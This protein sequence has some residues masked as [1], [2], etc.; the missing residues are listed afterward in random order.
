MATVLFENL[1]DAQRQAV[2]DTLEVLKEKNTPTWSAI[3]TSAKT[4]KITE[5][6][7]RIPKIS[8]MPGGHTAFTASSTSFNSAV[9]PQSTSMWVYPVRYALPMQFDGGFLRA[10]KGNNPDAIVSY[11]DTLENYAIAASKRMNQMTY[12][13]GT[14]VLAF[15]TNDEAAGAGVTVECD[16]T[17]TAAYGH[18]KGAAWLE[19]GHTYSFY[20]DATGNG[21]A[22]LL[23]TTEGKSSC[24]GTIT[25]EPTTGDGIYDVSAYNKYFRGFA[26]L[27]SNTS[28]VFQ[29]LDT[30][31]YTDLNAYEVDLAGAVATVASIEK[32]KAGLH[33]RNN[34]PK[35]RAGLVCFTTPGQIS[36]LRVQGYNLSQY[37]RNDDNGDVVKGVAEKFVA[38]DT[39][40]VQDADCDED[41][42]YF[43][44]ISQIERFEEMP[45]GE[46]NLD[47]QELRMY[48]GSNN[49]GSDTY[50]RAIGWVGNLGVTGLPRMSAYIKR[51]SITDIATQVNS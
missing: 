28:R 8:R 45:F 15:A 1:G 50:Q 5:K 27:I 48:L 2:A 51:A 16:T 4:R 13:D 24:V 22:T 33:V 29:G 10:F 46:Y 18:T 21:D 39:V 11:Q 49:T 32:A 34:D 25:N 14:G 6:G 17:A 19:A 30:S 43:V 36:N 47:G 37:I 23:V 7:F 40:F 35:S 42:F 20:P 38:G 41:R 44:D 31:V 26:H 9:A 3:K 12:G